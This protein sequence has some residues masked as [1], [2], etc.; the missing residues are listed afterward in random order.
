MSVRS[1]VILLAVCVTVA[2]GSRRCGDALG[3][4]CGHTETCCFA[5]ET[6]LSDAFGNVL[7]HCCPAEAPACCGDTCCTS[8]SLCVA[9]CATGSRSCVAPTGGEANA[10]AFASTS[11]CGGVCC[12]GG[13]DGVCCEE[14]CGNACLPRGSACCSPASAAVPAMCHAPFAACC[15][16]ADGAEASC[17]PE[18]ADCCG[19]RGCGGA[20]ELCCGGCECC[21]VAYATCDEA[22]RRCEPLMPPL[23]RRGIFSYT[24]VSVLLVLL[25]AACDSVVRTAVAET[26]AL[27]GAVKVLRRLSTG[28]WKKQQAGDGCDG[29]ERERLYTR[30]GGHGDAATYGSG[31]TVM[32]SAS[33][34]LSGTSSRQ[35]YLT[36]Q[37]A[38]LE[39]PFVP[40]HDADDGRE[41]CWH[42]GHFAH[43]GSGCLASSV[44]Q[45]AECVGC[46][47]QC[48]RRQC[49]GR[50]P[51]GA[52]YSSQQR[53]RRRGGHSNSH[54]VVSVNVINMT[55]PCEG[56]QCSTCEPTRFCRCTTCACPSCRPFFLTVSR[57]HYVLVLHAASVAT[58]N[59]Y[60]ALV[61]GSW[62]F[63]LCAALGAA[64]LVWGIQLMWRASRRSV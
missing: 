63:A 13:S 11:E 15:A 57:R 40:A 58:L 18:D 28:K 27:G 52:Q 5:T 4:Y 23:V 24:A 33:S 6:L 43:H 51:C 2:S 60:T 30:S 50:R 29:R 53:T 47:G 14:C 59:A 34:Q 49:H 1:A 12:G 16:G 46:R 22:A 20:D 26:G 45:S 21:D 36:P 7:T 42:C 39:S 64:Y 25:W 55:C 19:L 44:N 62:R 3:S 8:S 35:S 41:R 48:G 31:G 61:L 9:D 54:E 17:C 56:C 37:Q 10:A 38:Y 32:H